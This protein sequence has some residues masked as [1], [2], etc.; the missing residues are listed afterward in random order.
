MIRAIFKGGV[1]YPLDAV[2]PEW[3]DGQELQVGL[4]VPESPND[5]GEA[6]RWLKEMNA[7]MAN[8]NDPQEWEQIERTLEEA[9]RQA[10][11]SVR[12][13]MGLST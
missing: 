8:L 9:D 3:A 4:T 7:L 1:I 2:P 11:E 6:D 5:P 10:K 12:R 13:D